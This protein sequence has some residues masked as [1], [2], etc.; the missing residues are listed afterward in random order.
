MAEASTD[1]VALR[2]QLELLTLENRRIAEENRRIAE[3]NRSK[4]EVIQRKDEEN[5]RIAEESRSKDE[6][7]QSKDEENRRI[8][9]ES[10]RIAEEIQRKDEVI[11]RKDEVIQ[12]KDEENRRIAEESRRKDEE[13]RRIAEESRRKD[14]ENRRIAEESRRKDEEN[15][16]IAEESRRKD[17]ALTRAQEVAFFSELSKM[18]LES[19]STG[20]RNTSSLK[21]RLVDVAELLHDLPS[22]NSRTMDAFRS[23]WSTAFASA[24][25]GAAVYEDAIQENFHSFFQTFLS[26]LP[27]D[28]ALHLIDCSRSGFYGK[29]QKGDLFF[30]I[31][32]RAR[33]H[34]EISDMALVGELKVS[35]KAASSKA[36]LSQI[37]ERF[38]HMVK[39]PDKDRGSYWG[40]SAS[41]T[42]FQI[43]RL[44]V[45]FT[46]NEWK[47][48]V[49]H[50]KWLSFSDEC[51]LESFC[52]LCSAGWLS[53]C[54]YKH[55]KQQI[56][57][58]MVLK[59]Q[60]KWPHVHFEGMLQRSTF[61][62][63]SVEVA[64]GSLNGEP[65][66]AKL[67]PSNK[68]TEMKTEREALQRLASAEWGKF[69]HWIPALDYHAQDAQDGYGV[70]C[71][72]PVGSPLPLA[73]AFNASER[74]LY[75]QELIVQLCSIIL[76]ADA[77]SV[78]HMDVCPQNI[79]LL[80]GGSDYLFKFPLCLVDWGG[81]SFHGKENAG[82][83]YHLAFS[84][85]WLRSYDGQ[86]EL[87]E[88]AGLCASLQQMVLTVF[89]IAF[90]DYFS[91]LPPKMS[92]LHFSKDKAGTSRHT[93]ISSADT[94]YL[95][96]GKLIEY[97]L[98][99]NFTASHCKDSIAE[100]LINRKALLDMFRALRQDMPWLFMWD[101][102]DEHL[103]ID[104]RRL[105][106]KFTQI[107]NVSYDLTAVFNLIA[108]K[109]VS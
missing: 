75:C 91:W 65:I 100:M 109:N 68:L 64:F 78:W 46:D 44:Q 24:K 47:Q 27:E 25:F 41:D 38:H 13:N 54:Q 35:T 43:V 95:E 82:F 42:E 20:D 21:P 37:L 98:D 88:N 89:F 9:E 48:T 32:S 103:S 11:Q 1:F 71:T 62:D 34:V 76:V 8:A 40:F 22:L 31:G 15:R 59:L 92:T 10:R 97:L 69:A 105:L 57:S 80:Q 6:V 83:Q 102:L 30:S 33:K 86:K 93:S 87:E 18:L 74:L 55:S 79:V 81:S 66:V 29:Y 19:M 51:A 50:S 67:F 45:S 108:E 36:S 17:E 28:A 4:D 90:G 52:R 58:P 72:S 104:S 70:L 60:E 99:E 96:R 49:E 53:L 2:A 3:E 85:S 73:S 107:C 94:L 39:K 77:R 56:L 7:I 106:E 61:P 14:E 16:R 12:R 23:C 84:P 26:T 63:E 5:R 101:E